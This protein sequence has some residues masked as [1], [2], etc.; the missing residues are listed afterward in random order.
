VTILALHEVI[1]RFGDDLAF[2]QCAYRWKFGKDVDVWGDVLQWRLHKLAPQYAHD[3][4]SMMGTPANDAVV[5]KRQD[6]RK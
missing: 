5:Q 2:F 4:I 3:F 6:P 1:R